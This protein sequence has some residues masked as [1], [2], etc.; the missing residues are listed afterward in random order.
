[1]A[2]LMTFIDTNL[3]EI[4]VSYL[5][6]NLQKQIQVYLIP[7]FYKRVKISIEVY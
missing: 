4:C 1:M 5:K 2:C 6:E 3:L 7:I